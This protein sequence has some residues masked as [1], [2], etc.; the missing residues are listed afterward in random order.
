[1]LPTIGPTELII[2]FV[3]VLIIFGI[4]RLPQVGRGLGQGIREFRDSINM[5][6]E[7]ERSSAQPTDAETSEGLKG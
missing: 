7:N 5:L 1:M 3:I 2:I 6:K 4:G